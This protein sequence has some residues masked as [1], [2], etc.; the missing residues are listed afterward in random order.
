MLFLLSEKEQVVDEFQHLMYE[1]EDLT[2][3]ERHGVW[4]KLEKKGSLSRRLHEA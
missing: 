4:E 3:D 2:P 1:N